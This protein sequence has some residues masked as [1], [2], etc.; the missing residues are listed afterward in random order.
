MRN[1]TTSKQ[2]ATATR[3]VWERSWGE[4]VRMA[5]LR[6]R[7]F[8]RAYP[9]AAHKRLRLS[10]ARW[11][12]ALDTRRFQIRWS[13]S[14]TAESPQPDRAR[15]L[16]FRRDSRTLTFAARRY[17]PVCG[18]CTRI[19]NRLNGARFIW[20]RAQRPCATWEMNLNS[21]PRYATRWQ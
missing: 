19:S 5:W 3:A 12:M 7:I 11:W 15:K 2:S 13:W 1:S 4:L 17:F 10:A 8:Q 6:S 9:E 14:K 16:K 20:L 21:S 18:T